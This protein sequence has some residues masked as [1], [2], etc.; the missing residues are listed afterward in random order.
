LSNKIQWGYAGVFP[1]DFEVWK[2]KDQ[3]LAKW[4]FNVKQGFSVVSIPLGEI[5][6]PGPRRDQL[7]GFI[8]KHGLQSV[9]H[10]RT[11]W[12]T[13]DANEARDEL[14]ATLELMRELKDDLGL[15]VG[16]G[17][18]PKTHRFRRD[19]PLQAQMDALADRSAEF[20][21]GCRELGVPF[22]FENHGDYYC[23]DL[24]DLCKRVPGLGIFL[25]TGNCYLIGERPVEA[26]RAAAPYVI[27]THWKDHLVHPD[28]KELK[29]VIGGASL[30]HGDVG[31]AQIWDD[32]WKLHPDPTSIAWEWELVPPKD[33]NAWTSLEESWAFCRS[34]PLPEGVTH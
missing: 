33:Q 26:C 10:V 9:A 30:G 2:A 12:I 8:Q 17:V 29:F 11:N 22:G 25:D 16:M 15:M 20:A 6:E 23:S 21:K 28:P 19:M 27:G 4:E 14:A 1:G 18:V 34:L 3:L 5:R 32:I 7:V 31:L 24:V 13:G